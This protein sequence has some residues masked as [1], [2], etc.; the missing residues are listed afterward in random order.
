MPKYPRSQDDFYARV[1][2]RLYPSFGRPEDG[3][4]KGGLVRIPHEIALGMAAPDPATRDHPRIIARHFTAVVDACLNPK[5]LRN[6]QPESIAWVTVSLPLA[7]PDSDKEYPEGMEVWF[8]SG[9]A[10]IKPLEWEQGLI[11][12]LKSQGH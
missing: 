3:D 8:I 10:A 6:A 1:F 5:T 11:E 2:I 7:L 9:D 4:I 12:W